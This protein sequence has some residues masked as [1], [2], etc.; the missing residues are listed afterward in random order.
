[1]P[2][3]WQHQWGQVREGTQKHLFN[4]GPKDHINRRILHS[5]LPRPSIRGIP[6][7]MV[8]RILMFL[9]PFGALLKAVTCRPPLNMEA[10]SPGKK[11][12]GWEA[13]ELP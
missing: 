10:G 2:T 5:G 1:M 9:W 11:D 3:S 12:A 4:R 8:D 7:I 13:Y 6:E